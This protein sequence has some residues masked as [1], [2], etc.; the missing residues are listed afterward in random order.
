MTDGKRSRKSLSHH[1]GPIRV[2]GD[3]RAAEPLVHALELAAKEPFDRWTHGFH[4]YPAR[5][6]PAIAR[7]L[8][9]ELTGPEASVLDPFCGSGTVLVEAL[10]GGRASVGLDLSPL[11][12]RLARV[13]CQRRGPRERAAFLEALRGVASRSEARVRARVEARAP[14]GA[15]E[16][17]YYVPHTLKE[18]AGLRE[19]IL[20]VPDRTNREPLMLVFSAIVVKFS[21][22]RADTATGKVERRIRKGL[23]TEFF[24]RKGE[25]LAER[26][27]E[28]FEATSR[29]APRPLVQEA[30][31]LDLPEGLPPGFRATLVLTSPPYGGTYDYASQHA[32]RY[33]WLGLSPGALEAREIGAR[34]AL[35]GPGAKARWDRELGAA[36]SGIRRA[37]KPSGGVVLLIGDAQ[38]GGR[39]VPADLQVRELAEGAG[40]ELVAGAS[41]ARPDFTGGEPRREHLLLLRP[42]RSSRLESPKS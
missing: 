25:E 18:L 40:L 1:G 31:A 34:R 13:K 38:I 33:A 6:H 19:E 35:K 4:T 14:L 26:W 5:M 12:V 2:R 21:K 22:Q 7:S 15:D 27:A 23:P 10:V 29:S 16:R 17:A 32:R 9:S 41:E 37:M 11:A 30:N 3:A 36:L 20:A 24:L 28:L 42:A 39:R 8:I